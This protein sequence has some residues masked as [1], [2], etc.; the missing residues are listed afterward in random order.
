MKRPASAKLGRRVRGSSRNIVRRKVP[1]LKIQHRDYSVGASDGKAWRESPSSSDD[2][3]GIGEAI[4]RQWSRRFH[5]PA[6]HK[7]AA[8]SN[9]LQ[10]GKNYA[11][12]FIQGAGQPTAITP[13]P[14]RRKAS[15][16][17][18]AGASET[19]LQEVLAQLETLPLQEIVIVLGDPTERMFNLGRTRRNTVIA[20]LSNSVDSDVG[21]ALGAK[22]TGVDTVLFVDGEHAVH[23]DILARF[24]WEC[25]TNC[26]IALNDLS[27]RMGLFHQRDRVD[28]FHEFLNASLNR[29]D[30]TINSMSVLPYAVNRHALDT[31]GAAA[32]AVPAKAHALAIVNGLKIGF[33]GSAVN[34]NPRNGIERD[35]NW[36]IAAGDHV[37]A[38]REAMSVRGSRLLFNDSTRN[39]SVLGE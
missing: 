9:I 6:R 27:A 34:G 19:A 12:G 37:E 14:I 11:A 21:R 7:N 29:E 39:R 17:L 10:S 5:E 20:S 31:L 25:E 24:L 13:V 30:L 3:L 36:R 22:L 8:W 4:H 38:W 1:T 23:A 26:D 28:R 33:G 16:V 15:A 35:A 18:C 2:P 32:L